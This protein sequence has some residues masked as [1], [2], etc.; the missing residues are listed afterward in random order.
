ML[1]GCALDWYMKFSIVPIGVVPKTLNQIRLGL[2]DEF[3]KPKYESQCITE[4]IEIKKLLTKSIWDFDH[5]FKTLMAKV[6]FQMLDVKQKEWFI[7]TLL[8]HI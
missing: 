4:I 1:R 5:R 7:V 6:S 2:I 3:K 8:P